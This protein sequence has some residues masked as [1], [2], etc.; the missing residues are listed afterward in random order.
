MNVELKDLDLDEE[1]LP[2]TPGGLR[3]RPACDLEWDEGDT[4]ITP[5][6]S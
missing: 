4:R 1:D 5:P 2:T 6:P 3:P